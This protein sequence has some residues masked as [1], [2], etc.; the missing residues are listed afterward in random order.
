MRGLDDGSQRSAFVQGNRER[1]RRRRINRMEV[2]TRDLHRIF[3][4]R[5]VADEML[6]E[7]G[8]LSSNADAHR[9][10]EPFTALDRVRRDDLRRVLWILARMDLAKFRRELLR[11]LTGS[12]RARNARAEAKEQHGGNG[13]E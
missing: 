4:K 7:R 8:M 3:V 11:L 5:D 1:H 12:V 13:A 10:I 6:G 2:R 9:D